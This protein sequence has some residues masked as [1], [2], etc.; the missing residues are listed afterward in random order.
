MLKT[1]FGLVCLAVLTTTAL[2]ASVHFKSGPTFS[3]QGL[4]LSASGSLSGIGNGDVEL[5]L[6]A[7]GTPSATCTNNGG[8]Q[9]AGQNPAAVSL[10]GVTY[11]PASD[12][13]SGT[14]SF[15][16]L[17]T[18]APAQ[19]TARQAGCPSGKWTAQITD[20]TF[21]SATITVIQ[22]GKVVLQQTFTP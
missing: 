10:S 20:V 11:I 13:K 5:R 1:R 2:A 19:P 8:N 12:I 22:D 15:S 6:T 9:A 17:I 14:L 21:T 4:V 18:E 3:D 16:N 7:T